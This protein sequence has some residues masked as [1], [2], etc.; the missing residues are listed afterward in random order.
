MFSILIAHYNNYDYFKDCYASILKQ[1]Y[2]DYE[3]IIVDDCSDKEVYEKLVELT[4]DDPKTKISRNDENKGVGYTKRKC[5][6]LA[7]GEICGFLDP[8]D[9]LSE[10]ALQIS[11]ENHSENTIATY[12]SF[13]LCNEKLQPIR[14]FPHSRSVK[15]N[16]KSFFNV[17]LEVN[18]FFTFKRQAYIETDGINPNLTSAVDQDL[19]LKLYEKGDFKFINTPLYFYRLHSNG[20]SQKTSKKKKLH[21]NWHHVILDT[22]KRRNID[23]LQGKKVA[24][25]NDLPK[26]L[27]LKQNNLFVRILRKFA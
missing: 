26:F 1:T 4:K 16:D 23:V 11:I 8:D 25:I 17:F 20:V 24:D 27:K 5:V 7:A 3:I 10:N 15:N 22:T 9:A 2:Q 21:L 12:S 18:H 6:E 19:Y 13:F 14:R